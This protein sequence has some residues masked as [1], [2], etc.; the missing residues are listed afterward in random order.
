MYSRLPKYLYQVDTS[1]LLKKL[2]FSKEG[3]L[4]GITDVRDES[5]RG[6]IRIVYILKRDAVPNVVLN[7]L[8]K[9]TELQTSFSVNNIALVNGRP[10]LLNLKE[11]HLSLC[12]TSS[13]CGIS[14]H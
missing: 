11:L 6:K 1:I 14:S 3:K 8:F 7:N 5:A 13:R 10:Q 4:E 12:R 9:H 2:R